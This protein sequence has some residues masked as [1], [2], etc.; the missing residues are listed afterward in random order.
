M[1]STPDDTN[2]SN[3]CSSSHTS[4]L[5]RLQQHR[6]QD[7]AHSQHTQ[8]TNPLQLQA[9]TLQQQHSSDTQSSHHINEPSTSGPKLSM[10]TLESSANQITSNTTT[11]ASTPASSSSHH[12]TPGAS[13]TSHCFVK[14]T[15]HKPVYCH[16]CTDLLWGIIGQGY[17]CE[18]L[19]IIG[20]MIFMK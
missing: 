15:F 12:Q 7:P 14:K 19:F 4:S 11:M 2:T 6:D 20:E 13:L 10:T 8:L 3:S 5:N 18:G 1:C 16:H 9:A 17:T